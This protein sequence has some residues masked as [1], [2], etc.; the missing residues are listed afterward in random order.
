[1]NAVFM[2]EVG[3]KLMEVERRV[4]RPTDVYYVAVRNPITVMAMGHCD[5]TQPHTVKKERWICKSRPVNDKDF[6]VFMFDRFE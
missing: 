5:Y 3:G 1:M 4:I 2:T 6:A